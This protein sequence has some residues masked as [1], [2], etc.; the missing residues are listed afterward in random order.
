MLCSAQWKLFNNKE[1]QQYLFIVLRAVKKGFRYLAVLYDGIR[2]CN[3]LNFRAVCIVSLIRVLFCNLMAESAK[4]KTLKLGP[5]VL[6]VSS[7][8]QW[9]CCKSKGF[10]LFLRP[11][12]F[13]GFCVVP[14][15]KPVTMTT[16]LYVVTCSNPFF[17]INWPWN[18]Q[19]E[20]WMNGILTTKTQTWPKI[21]NLEPSAWKPYALN[22]L[23]VW[24]C[25]FGKKVSQ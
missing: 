19:H 5:I 13:V 16:S 22:L 21:W 3:G 18:S 6:Y 23:P 14:T 12:V 2:E 7:F 20:T 11:E 17:V 24:A 25:F 1:L 9:F 10:V 8:G 4:N 15:W